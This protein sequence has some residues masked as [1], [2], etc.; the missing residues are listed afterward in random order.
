[1]V[2]EF[3]KRK[4]NILQAIIREHI[5]TASP[6]GSR[7][8]AKAYDLG[9]SP[10]TIRNEMSDLEEL[11]YL[12]QPHTSAGRV[13]S[14]KGYRFYVD[15]LMENDGIESSKIKEAVS[16]MYNEKKGIQGII[17]GMVKMLSRLT[18]YTTMISEPELQE[19]ILQ[20]IEL[21][22]VAR[23]TLLVVL[24]T[25]TGIVN[26][27][28]IKLQKDLDSNQLKN[29]NNYL[30]KRLK[31]EKLIELNNDLLHKVGKEL[32]KRINIS[33]KIYEIICDQINNIIEPA[34]LKVFLGGRS[35][36]LEQPEFNDIE[37]LKKV[38][39]L[40]DHEEN[41]RKIINNLPDK[42]IEVKI[43]HENNLE[44]IQ[45]FSIVYTTYHLGDKGMGKIVVIGPTRMQYP[46]VIST[47]DLAADIFGKII[48]N[49]SR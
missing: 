25:D 37:N 16:K 13:P 17:S 34:N 42:G 24:I 15:V 6:I 44:E 23:R 19:S 29:I 22:R 9:V 4:K 1:M 40:F 46:R 31:G 21:I 2:E 43:G 28:V 32:I 49:A 14:D 33:E 8:L 20:N 38:L 5:L 27:K 7:T 12:K 47:V 3:K 48:S 35:Y 39:T 11:G 45:N 26:N 10:A 36:I 30:C 41:L 18:R